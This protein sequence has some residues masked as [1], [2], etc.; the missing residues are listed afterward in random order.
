[1]RRLPQIYFAAG[2]L[3]LAAAALATATRPEALAGFFLHP[4]LAAV[5]HAIT[6]GW[7][8]T[9]ILG[10]LVMVWPVALGRPLPVRRRDFA[11]GLLV[12]AA[13]TGIVAHLWIDDYRG[14]GFSGIVLGLGLA[15]PAGRYLAALPAARG[16]K[17]VRLCVGLALVN[18]FLAMTLGVLAAVDKTHP[19]LP[20]GH[21]DAVFGHLHLALLGWVALMVAG[22][23]YRLIPMF[24]PAHPPKGIRVWGTAVLLETGAVGIALAFYFCKPLVPWFGGI[25]AAGLGLFLFNV[26]WMLRHR[27]P[28]PPALRRPDIGMLHVLSALGYL[29][30]CIP[31]GLYLAISPVWHLEW[32]M[33]YGVCALLGFGA[34]MVLGVAMRLFPMFAWKEAW[35]GGGFKTLPRSP[36]AM[37]P[38]TLQWAVFC[39]WTP[40]VPLLA[41]GLA[42]TR[43]AVIAAGGWMLLAATIAAA[44]ASAWILR[45]AQPRPATRV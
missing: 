31:L 45:L 18:L 22:I 9:S 34:Q 2:H 8:L 1:V 40:A 33:V 38:R 15:V 21:L 11:A 37:A 25:A 3:A 24:L 19:F 36:H 42:T 32:I 13:I 41:W 16:P 28:A 29:L 14:V 6:L 7:L 27:V 30:V 43:V 12:L 35:V 20:S 44:L 26:A 17:G 23:G 39:L 10:A 4:H 5:V